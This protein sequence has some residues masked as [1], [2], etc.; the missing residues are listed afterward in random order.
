MPPMRM[1]KPA[2]DRR[3]ARPTSAFAE[4]EDFAV[5]LRD[6]LRD[7]PIYTLDPAAKQ[8]GHMHHAGA[9]DRGHRVVRRD[10]P[11][12]IR[13]LKI[14]ALDRV[15]AP[16]PRKMRR[17]TLRRIRVEEH[18]RLVRPTVDGRTAEIGEPDRLGLR[19]P[20]RRR[21]ALDPVRAVVVRVRPPGAQILVA[22]DPRLG[23]SAV[24][25]GGPHLGGAIRR[26]CIKP[27]EPLAARD[28]CLPVGPVVDR[29][30][31]RSASPSEFVEESSPSAILNA[32]RA[33][34]SPRF[35][36]C[37]LLWGLVHRVVSSVDRYRI[38]GCRV[39]PGRALPDRRPSALDCACRQGSIS[40]DRTQLPPP[41]PLRGGSTA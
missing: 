4:D 9:V 30:P 6:R 18:V 39:G 38:M 24:R 20:C 19:R 2:N 33:R 37:G 27:V 14:G 36:I 32:P 10:A 3:E 40:L 25:D 15:I 23:G 21:R 41:L 11:P 12:E 31:M 16:A 17:E 34:F 26:R 22:G 13:R 8:Q 35:V 1:R 7:H 29:G 28:V 5:S